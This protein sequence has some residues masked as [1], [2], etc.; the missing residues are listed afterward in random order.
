MASTNV[1]NMRTAI[2][3]AYPGLRW[4]S[5]VNAMEDNQVI[6]IYND[7]IRKGVFNKVRVPKKQSDPNFHQMTL[8]DYGIKKVF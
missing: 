1:K 2:I 7:F 3:S 5:R 8:W 4:E 6:A